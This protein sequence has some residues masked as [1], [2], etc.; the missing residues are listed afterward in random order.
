MVQMEII[1]ITIIAIITLFTILAYTRKMSTGIALFSI[2]TGLGVTWLL[3]SYMQM[4]IRPLSNSIFYGYSWTLLAIMVLINIF[5][6]SA[7]IIERGYNLYISEG[8]IGWA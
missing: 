7:I 3:N 1:Y 2:L 6:L 4:L 8:E 5:L